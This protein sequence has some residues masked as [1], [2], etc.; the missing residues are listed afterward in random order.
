MN[1]RRLTAL[2]A[3]IAILALSL[4]ACAQTATQTQP[5]GPVAVEIP[6][7]PAA[8]ATDIKVV[9]GDYL[10]SLPDNFNAITKVEGLQELLDNASPLLIDV[11]EPSEF[12]EGH[13]PGSI[14]IPLR[15]LTQHLDKIPTDT[16]V[17][18]TCAS[19]LRAS[20]ATTAL[21]MLG[22]TNVRDFYPSFK[23]WTAAD[24]PVSTDLVETVVVGAPDVD[25]V[26]LAE[27]EKFLV[28]MPEGY[29][30]VTKVEKLQ[31]MMDAGNLTI[32]DVRE[33]S[34]FAEGHIP[35]SVNIPVRT[36]M[37]NLDQIPT[38]QTVVL[39]CASGLRC[40]LATPALH[41]VGLTNVRAFTPSFKGW[42]AA[43]LEVVK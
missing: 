30:G 7:Q 35:G 39:T 15:S 18:M 16:P 24:L 28:N 29:F 23:G 14:N 33:P 4:G 22:Y 32:I 21:R 11:R 31:E 34:E 9:A 10:A 41:M 43:G 17:I 42:S 2:F 6:V 38:D 13:I 36:L 12:A 26:V 8:P 3:L 37:A 27:V 20:Y 25:P 40:S 19:G 1:A 5:V